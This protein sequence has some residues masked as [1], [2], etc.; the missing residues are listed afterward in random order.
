MESV[1]RSDEVFSGR[2]FLVHELH[3]YIEAA[4]L[5]VVVVVDVEVVYVESLVA[6]VE[7]LWMATMKMAAAAAAVAAVVVA[8]CTV[9]LQPYP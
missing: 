4:L 3:Y 7:H 2:A 1:H 8:A 9:L 5:A 6:L